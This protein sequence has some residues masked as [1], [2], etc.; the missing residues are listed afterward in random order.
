MVIIEPEGMFCG[1]RMAQLS[2][3]A[4][5][6]WPW[7]YLASNGYARIEINYRRLL[8]RVF[9]GFAIPPS[10]ALV[11]S[12]I[13]EYAK[14]YLL[15]LYTVNGQMWGQW[16]TSAKYLP[17]HKTAS[18]KR[19]PEPPTEAWQRWRD[20]Y[21]NAKCAKVAVLSTISEKIQ[22][23]TQNGAESG[24]KLRVDVGVDVGVKTPFIPQG[25]STPSPSEDFDL[26][27]DTPV[28]EKTVRIRKA[29]ATAPV[30]SELASN[31][32]ARHPK[33][34]TCFPGEAVKKLN[35]IFALFPKAEW[36]ALA[37][38]IDAMHKAKCVSPDWTKDGGQFSNGLRNWLDP[39]SEKWAAANATQQQSDEPEMICVIDTRLA[40]ILQR[41]EWKKLKRPLPAGVIEVPYNA[42]RQ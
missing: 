25:G 22:T 15:F 27:S 38:R 24:E 13:H 12:C 9:A 14:A 6:L 19:S 18:D 30:I 31:L 42:V 11:M 29:K 40:K 1:D 34:R 33:V 39:V 20:E 35:Q 37:D 10:E 5:N 4:K 28:S 2:D 21:A 36:P 23:F 8:N 17:R 7:L 41:P 32:C 26:K 3:E 16:D